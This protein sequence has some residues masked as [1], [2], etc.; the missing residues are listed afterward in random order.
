MSRPADLAVP[1]TLQAWQAAFGRRLRHGRRAACPAG[2]PAAR[3]A[4]YERLVFQRLRGFLD[5]C[6]PVARATLGEARW[7]R[8]CRAFLRDWDCVTPW[9]R[10]IPQ[11]LLAYLDSGACRQRLPRWFGELLRYEW[12][13]LAVDVME[14]AVPPHRPD[15]DLV[16]GVPLVNPALLSL[17]FAWPVQRIGPDFRPRQPEPVHLAV[18]RNALD[19]V[20]FMALSP[21][22]AR[23]LSL[24][25]GE[26]SGRIAFETLAAEL[27]RPAD[28][29]FIDFGRH[30][31]AELRHHGVLL[32][33]RT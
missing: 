5:R 23:L 24:L 15:G 17:A 7:T 25:D 10:E 20:C 18:Y 28:T 4:V 14:V 6:F 21:A 22:T 11:E 31:L 27:G 8:L 3:M 13:E 19:A 30:N 33:E 16:D 32:G 29:A 9:F 12:A 26:C 2:V 1:G